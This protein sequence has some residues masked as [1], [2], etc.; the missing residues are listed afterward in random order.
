[1]WNLRY[2]AKRSIR[3]DWEDAAMPRSHSLHQ[4][5]APWVLATVVAGTAGAAACTGTIG[6]PSGG[7]STKSDALCATIEPG[8]S[9]IRR[10]TRVEY[11]NTVRDLLGDTTKPADQFVVEEEA[12]GFNNQASALGVT[13]LL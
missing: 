5:T 6:D 10:M 13:Q 1:M 11:N 9:P 4:L 2:P 3:S 12:L 7:L 8:A